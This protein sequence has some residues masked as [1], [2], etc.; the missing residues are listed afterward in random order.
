[1]LNG[2]DNA[3]PISIEFFHEKDSHSKKNLKNA[4]STSPVYC[5]KNSDIDVLE[6][7]EDGKFIESII[8][9][10]A[11]ISDLKNPANNLGELMKVEYFIKDN[12]EELN[13]RYNDLMANRVH[14]NS[15]SFSKINFEETDKI[16]H[17]LEDQKIKKKEESELKTLEDFENYYL[18]NGKF[19]YPDSLPFHHHIYGENPQE[20]SKGEKEY[21]E[22][23]KN[24]IK[25]SKDAH[26]NKEIN[27]C[28][29]LE[30]ETN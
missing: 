17:S 30:D 5:C 29:N 3:L 20:I 8:G 23:Y 18:I 7:P 24:A 22:K 14:S 25:I 15:E 12:F 28:W 26:Y 27:F 10:K 11:L 19:I 16:K 2:K 1:M 4:H 9:N 21:L 6:E 13:K